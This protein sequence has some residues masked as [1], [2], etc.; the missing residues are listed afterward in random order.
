MST[1]SKTLAKELAEELLK[2]LNLKLSKAYHARNEA[3]EKVLIE[4]TPSDVLDIFKI[5]PQ[6]FSRGQFFILSGEGFDYIRIL[7]T[8]K[9][10]N[11]RDCNIFLVKKEA[12]KLKPF[13]D[14]YETLKAEI[15][16]TKQEVE[17]VLFGLR[18]FKKVIEAFPELE[19]FLPILNS[20]AVSLDLS[21]LKAKLK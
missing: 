21:L 18:T 12:E 9:I 1:V 7:T 16:K 5:Y 20:K 10:I 15:V 4:R 14:D 19:K 6:Y 11:S 2:P 17:V 3:L 13:F 8:N